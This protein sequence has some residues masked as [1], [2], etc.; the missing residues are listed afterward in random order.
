MTRGYYN[1]EAATA[2]AFRGG[3]FR[4]GDLAISMPT[5]IFHR[6]PHQGRHQSRRPEDLSLEVERSC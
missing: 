2:A 4:T 1:D 3:W 5:A 6:R